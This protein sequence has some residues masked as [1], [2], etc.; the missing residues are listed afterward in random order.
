M[1]KCQTAQARV[2]CASLQAAADFNAIDKAINETN[3]EVAEAS[4]ALNAGTSSCATAT[5]SD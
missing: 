1:L 2:A 3:E 4:A 5:S